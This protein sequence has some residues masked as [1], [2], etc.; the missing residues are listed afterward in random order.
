MNSEP[1]L[2]VSNKSQF[3]SNGGKTVYVEIYRLEN[4]KRWALSIDDEFG[5]TTV[6]D[7]TFKSEK[8]AILQAKKSITEDGIDEF[9]G[10]ESGKGEWNNSP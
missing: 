5:N 9:I 7:K 6:F 8:G 4:E 1:E 2:V 3:I 10:P